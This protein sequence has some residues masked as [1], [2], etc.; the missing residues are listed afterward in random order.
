MVSWSINSQ[1][2]YSLSQL[3]SGRVRGYSSSGNNLI[4]KDI[5]VNDPRDSYLYK[6]WIQSTNTTTTFTLNNLFFLRVVGEYQYGY[7]C[8]MSVY[9]TV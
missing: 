8:M 1:S 4:V 5:M 7:V 3:S 6:C 2:R 9:I